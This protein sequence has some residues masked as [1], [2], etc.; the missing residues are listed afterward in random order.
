MCAWTYYDDGEHTRFLLTSSC[1]PH[2]LHMMQL[3][4]DRSLPPSL[5]RRH[6]V[7]ARCWKTGASTCGR[8]TVGIPSQ[9]AGCPEIVITARSERMCCTRSVLFDTCCALPFTRPSRTSAL[10]SLIGPTCWEAFVRLKYLLWRKLRR[11]WLC[12]Y[13]VWKSQRQKSKA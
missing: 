7:V 13:F 10:L 1:L 12:L 11:L 5:P 2:R 4:A 9:Q 6:S 3:H 8:G